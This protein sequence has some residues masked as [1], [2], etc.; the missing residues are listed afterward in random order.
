VHALRGATFVKAMNGAIAFTL[1]V[2]VILASFTGHVY[3]FNN[4]LTAPVA[5]ASV[6]LFSVL[7]R[8]LNMVPYGVVAISESKPAWMRLDAF[9]NQAEIL[10][11][12][13]LLSLAY[14]D[15]VDADTAISASTISSI[16]LSIRDADFGWEP[17]IELGSE[18]TTVAPVLSGISLSVAAGEV[19]CV[20]GPVASGKSSLLHA[21]L[22]EM[23]RHNSGG[24]C[25]TSGRIAY[26]AQQNWI[27]N[28]TVRD[29]IVM[30]GKGGQPGT[31]VDEKRYAATL[32]ACC[33]LH[34]LKQLPG[35]DMTEIGE[36][37]VTLSGGQQSRIALARCVYSD[38]DLYLLDDPLSAVDAAI[39][40]QLRKRLLDKSS[41]GLL[42]E[43]AVVIVTHQL[44]VLPLADRVVVMD[45]GRIVHNAPY[46][47]LKAQGISFD[48]V[49]EE[50]I[51]IVDTPRDF[52]SVREF[53]SM[54]SF[55]SSQSSSSF[56]ED[57]GMGENGATTTAEDRRVGKVG[58]NVYRDYIRQAGG[59]WTVFGVIFAFVASQVARSGAEIW[60]G[61][62]AT[63]RLAEHDDKFYA[64]VYLALGAGAITFSAG[65]AALYAQKSTRASRECH[66][67]LLQRILHA[68][69]VFFEQTPSG[70][71]LSRFSSDCESLDLLLPTYM[72]DFMQIVFYSL[73]AVVVIGVSIPWFLPALVPI[74]VAFR[75][76][77]TMYLLSSRELKRIESIT[78]SP[79]YSTIV[80]TAAGCVSVRA[81]AAEGSFASKLD[82]CLDVNLRSYLLFQCSGRWLGVRLDLLSAIVVFATSLVTVIFASSLNPGVAGVALTQSLTLT[83]VLQWATRQSAEC[84]NSFTSIE[85]VMEMA[86]QTPVEAAALVEGSVD[87]NS[88]PKDGVLE[89]TDVTL[90]YRPELEPSLVGVSFKTLPREKIGMYALYLY[91]V[92]IEYSLNN[93]CANSLR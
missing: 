83:G 35:S 20:V 47:E 16:R 77:Q 48:G 63:D 9:L 69:L 51:S 12:P 84:E 18:G 56:V 90:K 87:A 13:N 7:G 1:P 71:I 50:V 49:A 81:F 92:A 3:V 15:Q 61:Y 55:G 82:H 73:G 66:E 44:S 6:G 25:R 68:S 53:S 28:A 38:A 58:L 23:Y 2:F 37:G 78:R 33:L 5:F 93:K 54:A 29:N 8:V 91:S 34:D 11:L 10:R 22:G 36:K 24:D 4:S 80:E 43:K 64:L 30:F 57:L 46:R 72:Q 79:V 39:G 31:V 86:T 41:G 85:R 74:T 89:F 60:L 17:K 52:R 42:T 76:I 27:L 19:I 88:W 14:E 21:A 59:V 67:R 65:R 32:R 75:M 45:G 70:R 40:R 62:W 26:C